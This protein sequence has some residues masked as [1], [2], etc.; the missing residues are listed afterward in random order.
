MYMI[1]NTETSAQQSEYF[2]KR[3]MCER[4]INITEHTNKRYKQYFIYVLYILRKTS[5]MVSWQ[6]YEIIFYILSRNWLFIK[7]IFK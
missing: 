4:T 2:K 6:I 1:Y 7:P 5:K 3:N